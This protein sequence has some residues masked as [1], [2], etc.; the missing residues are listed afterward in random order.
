MMNKVIEQE[1]LRAPEQYMWLHRRFKTRPK[2]EPSLY[3]DLDKIHH[4]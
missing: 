1:I 3:G 2:G 4:R